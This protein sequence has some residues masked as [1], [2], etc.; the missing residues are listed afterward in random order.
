[1]VCRNVA[2]SYLPPPPPLL[3]EGKAFRIDFSGPLYRT[4]STHCQPPGSVTEAPFTDPSQSNRN[5]NNP[6]PFR[7]WMF[8]WHVM[9]DVMKR[10]IGGGRGGM[11]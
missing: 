11:E 9:P 10:T 3:C 5:P 6:P 8:H 1:M 2:R 4:L 7:K